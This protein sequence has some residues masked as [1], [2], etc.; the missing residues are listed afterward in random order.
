MVHT[1]GMNRR[2]ALELLGGGGIVGLS[3]CLGAPSGR[4]T[5][6]T[7]SSGKTTE[8]ARDTRRVAITQQDTVAHQLRVEATMVRPTVTET[9]P[10][11]IR[12]T[13]TNEGQ[14]RRMTVHGG[15]PMFMRAWASRPFGVLLA[16]AR[17]P[18]RVV[19]S[20]PRWIID[21]PWE[22][23]TDAPGGDGGCGAVAYESGQSRRFER[24]LYD[25]GRIDGYFDPGTVEFTDSFLLTPGLDAERYGDGSVTV[26]WG[27]ELQIE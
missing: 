24:V 17:S 21:P 12:V 8:S 18:S 22:P 20:G 27:I 23:G 14:A 7:I 16:D 1:E 19:E 5:S 11:R 25:D 9:H 2:R 10:A 4:P 6:R 13:V 26:R 3:G 15:C